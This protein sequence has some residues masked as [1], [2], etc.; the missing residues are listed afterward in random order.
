[1]E[2]ITGFAQVEEF[3]N[4]MAVDK[5]DRHGCKSSATL[6]NSIC[7]CNTDDLLAKV[8]LCRHSFCSVRTGMIFGTNEKYRY[9][10]ALACQNSSYILVSSNIL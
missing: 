10:N 8:V 2:L 9:F 5:R 3:M 1:M 7:C 6:V 4:K